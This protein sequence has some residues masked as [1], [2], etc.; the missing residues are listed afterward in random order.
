MNM[1]IGVYLVTSKYSLQ[2]VLHL[3]EVK[4]FLH[5]IFMLYTKAYR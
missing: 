5:S 1:Q 3:R 4:A 2:S